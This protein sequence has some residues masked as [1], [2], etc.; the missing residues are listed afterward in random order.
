M[1]MVIGGMDSS[2]YIE[3]LDEKLTKTMLEM[4]DRYS[5]TNL[6]FQW[7]GNPKHRS[8]ETIKW[9]KDKNIDVM[10]WPPQSPDLN[11]IEHL[12]GELKKELG[13]HNTIAKSES[14]LLR[15]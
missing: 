12:W 6:I 13:K 8:K 7:D 15:P 5:Y 4:C 3:I 2:Q 14:K 11:S 10:E 9:L 1:C